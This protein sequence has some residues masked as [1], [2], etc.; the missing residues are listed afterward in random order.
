MKNIEIENHD[1]KCSTKQETKERGLEEIRK[2]QE[3]ATKKAPEFVY[4]KDEDPE[5]DPR[6]IEDDLK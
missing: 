5:P 1:A 3:V 4:N 6:N 2:S